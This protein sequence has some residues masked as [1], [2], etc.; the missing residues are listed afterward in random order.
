MVLAGTPTPSDRPWPVFDP[1]A[2][3]F[4]A[5]LSAAL[6]AHPALG[7][8]EEGAALA[9]WL[10]RA[11][12]DQLARRH[13]T[14]RR[15]GVGLVFHVPPAN[16][17]LLFAYSLAVGLLA[18][19][20][21]LLRL[22]QRRD[23]RSDA[24][25]QV[26]RGLLDDPKWAE[27]AGRIGLISYPREDTE[28]TADYLA[29]CDGRVIWGGDGTVNA[30]SV[31]P[32]R[33]GAAALCFPDRWSA[34]LLRQSH[35]AGL[36]ES[37]LEL[38]CRRFYNDTYAMDQ[39]ACS[40]PRLVFWLEDGHPE[41]RRRFWRGVAAQAAARYELTGYKAARK[42]EAVYRLVMEEPAAE[43]VEFPAGNLLALVRLARPASDMDGCRLAFGAFLEHRVGQVEEIAP[44]LTRRTQT[45]TQAGFHRE[46]LADEIAALALPGVDRV[47]DVGQALEFD[48]VWDGKDLIARLSRMIP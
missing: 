8:D 24:F 9:F 19:N 17:P 46:A 2:V 11:H 27:L 14:A 1:R 6:R 10:R 45:L 47:V 13:G 28:R 16:V 15:L 48:T 33:P 38:L 20:G 23:W 39:N 5:A 25:C 12:L 29:H 4:L 41:A 37:A 35:V 30:L 3:D 31:L 42:R 18:G 22:S 43:H 44:F 34:C 26:L 7:R 40:S 32:G 21:N 36:D